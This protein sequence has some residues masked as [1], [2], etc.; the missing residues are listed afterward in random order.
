MTFI[1]KLFDLT[2]Y[3]LTHFPPMYPNDASAIITCFG[4]D[5]YEP[6]AEMDYLANLCFFPKGYVPISTIDRNSGFIVLN[7]EI[8]RYQDIIGTFR[9]EKP[10]RL[11]I[12]YDDAAEGN[13]IEIYGELF[14]GGSFVGYLGQASTT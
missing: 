12:A 3:G 2:V 9:Y 5:T 6:G 11:F 10:L 14:T 13:T 1:T 8:D 7:F 4:H